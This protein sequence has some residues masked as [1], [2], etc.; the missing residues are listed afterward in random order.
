[1]TAE[2][3]CRQ[4]GPLGPHLVFHLMPCAEGSAHPVP[5]NQLQPVTIRRGRTKLGCEQTEAYQYLPSVGCLVQMS[6]PS[7]IPNELFWGSSTTRNEMEQRQ[8]LEALSSGQ[9]LPDSFGGQHVQKL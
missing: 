1:M 8:Q 7:R 6:L 9:N 3:Q 2:G 5:A 4:G